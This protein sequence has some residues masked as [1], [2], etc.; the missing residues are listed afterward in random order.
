MRKIVNI[1]LAILLILLVSVDIQAR[2]LCDCYGSCIIIQPRDVNYKL[3]KQVKIRDGY[4][5]SD[6]VD[7]DHRLPLCL[8]GTN[9]MDNLQ[10]LTEEEHNKKTRNDMLLFYYIQNCFM[11]ID[12]AQTEA[13]NYQ[14]YINK[15]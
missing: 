12:E 1:L 7:I 4:N 13:V 6:Q 3:K 2:D 15:P 5:Y 14:E 9:D 10:A 8:G 11:T